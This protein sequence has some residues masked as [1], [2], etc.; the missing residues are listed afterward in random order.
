MRCYLS[1]ASIHLPAARR[2]MDLLRLYG[3]EITFDWTE[4]FSQ[5]EQHPAVYAAQDLAGVAA[6]EA[7]I[8]LHTEEVSAGAWCEI[9]FALALR[10]P[11]LAVVSGPLNL[12]RNRIFLFAQGVTV[13]P[14]FE[15]LMEELAK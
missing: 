7:L 1:M 8:Y 6:A 9:G 11:V 15:Q 5:P 12:Q 2:A 4:S 3:H 13:F 10:K 14:S